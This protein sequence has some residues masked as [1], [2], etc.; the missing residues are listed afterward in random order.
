M[1]GIL[2]LPMVYLEVSA[3]SN[4]PLMGSPCPQA[5]AL[6]LHVEVSASSNFP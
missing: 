3:R 5:T 6:L 2:S 1:G 4:F